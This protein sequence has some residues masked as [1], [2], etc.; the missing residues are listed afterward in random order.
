MPGV[1]LRTITKKK[2]RRKLHAKSSQ[3]AKVAA[4][5]RLKMRICSIMT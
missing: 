5:T 4:L 1:Q 2:E 3:L